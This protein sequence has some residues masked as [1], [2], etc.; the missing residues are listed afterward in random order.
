MFDEPYVSLSGDEPL[1][2][3]GQLARAVQ[4]LELAWEIRQAYLAH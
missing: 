4:L 3:A 2:C 1:D